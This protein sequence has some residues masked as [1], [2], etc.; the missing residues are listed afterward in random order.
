MNSNEKKL[1]SSTY[2]GSAALLR[3]SKPWLLNCDT[4]AV[5]TLSSAAGDWWCSCLTMLIIICVVEKKI[6]KKLLRILSEVCCLK[7][8]LFC[9]CS[10]SQCMVSVSWKE[11]WIQKNSLVYVT[12]VYLVG[13]LLV[14]VFSICLVGIQPL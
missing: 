13:C 3:K 1:Y 12:V 11:K 2:I 9:L 8:R 6:W 5:W 14:V 7:K 10:V 4:A